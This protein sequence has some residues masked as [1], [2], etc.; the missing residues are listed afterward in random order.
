MGSCTTLLQ[1]HTPQRG[2][3]QQRVSC[4]ASS[5]SSVSVPSFP[6]G[7]PFKVG[8]RASSQQQ[9]SQ[10]SQPELVLQHK[11]RHA[12]R[13]G[14][15]GPSDAATEALHARVSEGAATAAAE[16]RAFRGLSADLLSDPQ[17]AGVLLP[18]SLDEVA[19][20]STVCFQAN[21]HGHGQA[22]HTGH[23]R[24][25]G[26][27]VL[28]HQH[29]HASQQEPQQLQAAGQP[30]FHHQLARGGPT[31]RHVA[32]AD[33]HTLGP[34][35]HHA[36]ALANGAA[37][38]GS[39]VNGRKVNGAVR[40]GSSPTHIDTPLHHAA[41]VSAE[42]VDS[43]SQQWHSAPSSQPSHDP[44][45][46]SSGSL[47]PYLDA[48]SRSGG[49]ASTSEPAP[50]P[51]G[52]G[53]GADA[54]R[55]AGA[56]ARRSQGR[57]A[58]APLELAE[59]VAGAGAVA[60]AAAAAAAV[61]TAPPVEPT[62]PGHADSGSLAAGGPSSSGRSHGSGIASGSANGNG[63]ASGSSHGKAPWQ[64]AWVPSA[65]A[66]ASMDAAEALP[67]G[68]P[69]GCGAPPSTL[70]QQ[71]EGEPHAPAFPSRGATRGPAPRRR[72]RLPTK[73][74]H[75]ALR[76]QALLRRQAEEDFLR[77]RVDTR[78]DLKLTGR[79]MRATHWGEVLQALTEH[80]AEFEDRMAKLVA[81]D[82][83]RLAKRALERAQQQQ[84]EGQ[85][86]QARGTAP[87]SDA[88]GAEAEAEAASPPPPQRGSAFLAGLGTEMGPVPIRKMPFTPQHVAAML[89]RTADLVHTV[90][91]PESAADAR[92]LRAM[93]EGLA[94]MAA[95]ML[96]SPGM[97]LREIIMVFHS[98]V[99]LRH[100]AGK[101]L[102][103]ALMTA[104]RERFYVPPPP[105][106]LP[107][108]L[109]K[110]RAAKL[111]RQ[112][113]QPQPPPQ[114]AVQS[115]PYTA[116]DMALLAWC[117][118]RCGMDGM[119]PDYAAAYFEAVQRVVRDLTA[120]G[121]GLIL[122]SLARLHSPP[123]PV[124]VKDLCWQ[125]VRLMRQ[126]RSAPTAPQPPAAQPAA[127]GSGASP[128]ATAAAP[129]AGAKQPEAA[130]AE[131]AASLRFA[132]L[133]DGPSGSAA[134]GCQPADVSMSLWALATMRL[135][136]EAACPA[137]LPGVEAFCRERMGDF[138]QKDVANLVWALAR[139]QHTPSRES[140]DQLYDTVRQ[141][142]PDLQPHALSTV[143][144]GV[145]QLR[146]RPPAGWLEA[147]AGR[148]ADVMPGFTPQG[149]A[150]LIHAFSVVGYRPQESWMCAFH[151]ALE[152]HRG[153]L[154][155]RVRDKVREAYRL[156]RFRPGG[157]AAPA[158]STSVAPPSAAAA[159][160]ER[161]P[162]PAQASQQ[163]SR[164]QQQQAGRP[165]H[166]R[167]GSR[168]AQAAAASSASSSA[169]I[170][171][172][173]AGQS[174]DRDLLDELLMTTL[175]HGQDEAAADAAAAADRNGSAAAPAVADVGVLVRPSRF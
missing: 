136:P 161:Q 102:Y 52:L 40:V 141:M 146:Q 60:A 35:T 120:Q 15:A 48:A 132:P 156:L 124:L 148:A 175:V 155:P 103:L 57:G 134:H 100:P 76:Q 93:V 122:Y 3:Q 137:L 41:P 172:S 121:V 42:W 107:K 86:Q 63:S 46:S 157:T 19:E 140:T 144:Y 151:S 96:P 166:V 77:P 174:M 94:R 162:P 128:A 64:P 79:V 95:V 7:S 110:L 171:S 32:V 113:P 20:Q 71:P 168:P 67:P 108:W 43:P 147:V 88:A 131:P 83:R 149:L 81:K 135:A 53:L 87:Q 49:V 170:S 73:Q 58:R 82:Q 25:P 97:R 164:L 133:K 37:V 5:R 125:L 127:H 44:H 150:L 54:W 56:A 22:H 167:N 39:A 99:R 62:R 152:S 142:L 12:R 33:P 30:L 31:Q 10:Q 68:H 51:L 130:G 123:P 47:L 114:P 145:A 169:S 34:A 45:H 2:L 106:P 117:A 115:L 9:P 163:A 65:P 55:R 92:R 173:L 6:E 4:G 61:V 165:A 129:A 18:P 159:G 23:A 36:A 158:A 118:A 69:D 72:A 91:P 50:S 119:R 160:A 14:G 101:P 29:G 80:K 126:P 138:G 104:A 38:N 13:S 85:E 24:S 98:L 90:G 66:T 27:Q 1:R 70:L 26:H 116:Q 89:Q 111:R 139:L 75:E 17:S 154:D 21:G 16:P 78:F 28:H 74:E 59:R 84:R 8:T 105:P 153:S 143:L 11:N 109:V 112:Q